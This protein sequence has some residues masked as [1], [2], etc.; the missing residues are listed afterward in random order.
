MN[1]MIIYD[2]SGQ[3][4]IHDLVHSHGVDMCGSHHDIVA[5]SLQENHSMFSFWEAFYVKYD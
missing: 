4:W 1:D 3:E 2:T 5:R